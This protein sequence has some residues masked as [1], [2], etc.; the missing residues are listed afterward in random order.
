ME[1]RMR[2]IDYY[3]KSINVDFTEQK[4]PIETN[5]SVYAI[6]FNSMMERD[7]IAY[8]LETNDVETKIYYQPLYNMSVSRDIYSRILAL[9]IYP[10]IEEHLPF[11]CKTINEAL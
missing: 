6:L 8:C 7:R 11:I 1:Q 9:P 5:Y 4:I 2:N 10:G 3:R